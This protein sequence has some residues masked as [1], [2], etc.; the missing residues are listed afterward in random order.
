[1]TARFKRLSGLF[2]KREDRAVRRNG[3]Q[4]LIGS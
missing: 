4:S 3:A 2:G 1:M